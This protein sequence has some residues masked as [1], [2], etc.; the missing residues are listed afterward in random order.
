[1]QT[2]N[3]IHEIQSD[4]EAIEENSALYEEPNFDSRVK[5]IDY[6]EFNVIERIEGLLL[7][8][9]Q[10]DELTRLKRYAERVKRQLEEIDDN[11]FRRLGADI[12]AGVCA[13]T[14]LK[15]QIDKYI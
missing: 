8:P 6:I 7:A 14:T 10:P 12:Q 9:S 11:L 3:V 1:V 13:G 5:A 15:G 2:T 4:I